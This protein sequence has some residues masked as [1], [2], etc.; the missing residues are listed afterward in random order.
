M[1][2]DVKIMD[3]ITSALMSLLLV[4]LVVAGVW[5]L[6]QRPAFT[7]KVIKV[8]GVQKSTLRHVNG[9]TI[10]DVALPKVKGNFFTT[11][12]DAVRL[13]FEAVPW[14]RKA[15]VKREWPN[16]LV[17][18]I[19]EHAVLGTWGDRGDLI[20]VKGDVFT[21]NLGEAEEDTE[22]LAFSGPEG[23]ER[24]V[25]ARYVEFKKWFEQINLEPS[26]VRYSSRYAWSVVLN[27]GLKVEL[28]RVQD[29]TTLQQR[30]ERLLNAYPYLTSAWQGK[31]DSV[32]MR[33]PNG[34]ALRTTH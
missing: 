25:L 11:N 17:V 14:V 9:L 28:G 31:I 22:L 2:Q 30:V 26:A 34:M 12:L 13:A 15:S 29:E 24:E 21:A 3:A 18:T 27:N 4:L 6:M 19:E 5:W 16:K 8:E 32:D 7:L 20:S 33:Y 1:W 10:R 23:S